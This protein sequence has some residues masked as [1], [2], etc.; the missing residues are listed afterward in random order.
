MSAAVSTKASTKKKNE[1]VRFE[2]DG[3]TAVFVEESHA[4]PIVSIVIALRTG[5]A[6]DPPGKDGCARMMGRM[7]RRGCVGMT[8]HEIEDAVDRLGGELSIDLSAS[9]LAFHAQVIERNLDAFVELVARILST[10]TFEAEQLGRLQRETVAEIIEGRDSDRSL[11]Q[12]FFRR[13]LYGSHPYGRSALG[14]VAGIESITVDDVRAFY[15]RFLTQTNAVIGFSGDITTERARTLSQALM[16]SLPRGEKIADPVAEPKAE[17]GRRLV[18]VDKPERTQTQILIGSLGTWPHDEDHVAIGVANAVFGGTFTS[19]LMREVRSK[20]GWSYGAYARLAIDRQ[21]QSFSMWT[22][23]SATDAPGCIGLEIEL[24]EA[25]IE[26]G[27]T[28]RELA[29]IKRYL[30]RSQAFE[31]D[32]A[33]KRLHQALDI[34]LLDLP[35]DYH[36]GYADKVAKITPEEANESVKRRL[37]KDNLLIVVVGTEAQIGDAVRNA[38]P[39]LGASQVLP[40]DKE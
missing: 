7:L 31:V 22:F 8:T 2:V 28:P 27:V 14:T 39:G 21:R 25:F 37:S 26:K 32:T 13:A 23:P 29:F 34:E 6:F 10:P 19:R 40:F 4:L 33:S 35:A 38:I 3:G 24:L 12:G 9:S 15:K 17:G 36:S 5:S 18:I 30:V 20:R 11:A 16:K 1:T